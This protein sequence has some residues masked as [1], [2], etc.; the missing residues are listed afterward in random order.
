MNTHTQTN[1]GKD[2]IDLCKINEF[3]PNWD[4]FFIIQAF[5]TASR[6]PCE[7]LHVGCVIVKNRHIIAHGYNG[8]LPGAPHEGKLVDGH[9][10]MTIH[11]EQN[12]VSDCSKRG[13][14][15]EGCTAYIT[16]FP[17]I[18]C[19]KVLIAAGIREIKYQ[20]DYN[21]ND[22]VYELTSLGGVLIKKL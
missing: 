4:E 3:R 6:S 17:C 12:A 8:F 14:Q 7:R 13:V 19:A 16:H 1:I 21:N 2:I 9:E 22:L 5:L 11:A 10:Q 20:D 15:T 18:N